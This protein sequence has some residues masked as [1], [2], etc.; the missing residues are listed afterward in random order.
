MPTSS[1]SQ[2]SKRTVTLTGD[3]VAPNVKIPGFLPSVF[4]SIASSST[5]AVNNNILPCKIASDST[6]T[7]ANVPYDTA[8]QIHLQSGLLNL[9]SYVPGADK[10]VIKAP[11]G[12]SNRSTAEF[13]I[14]QIYA[15]DYKVNLNS[16]TPY[17]V[18]INMVNEL[19]DAISNTL[20]NASGS[21]AL[22]KTTLENKKKEFLKKNS[23]FKALKTTTPASYYDDNWRGD[24]YYYILD[25]RG[26]HSVG[27]SATAKFTINISG[28]KAFGTAEITPDIST[29]STSSSGIKNVLSTLSFYFEGKVKD[30]V[31][32]FRRRGTNGTVQ[33][34]LLEEWTIFPVAKG[35]AIKSKNI[36]FYNKGLEF[37]PSRSILK[38][39]RFALS[40]H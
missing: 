26:R 12:L 17:T 18:N 24:V 30:G 16:I 4:Q 31:I 14:R 7:I 6:F 1:N 25:S 3:I 11:F 8:Y 29:Y 19:A 15:N 20:S 39:D 33:E 40:D 27:V 34:P 2:S 5:C 9:Y 23:F 13:L 22:L 21:L 28:D 10:A 36:D 38:I 37:D 35:L 32:Q